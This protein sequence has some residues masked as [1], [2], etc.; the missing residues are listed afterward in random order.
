M[1]L[2]IPPLQAHGDNKM[3]RFLRKRSAARDIAVYLDTVRAMDDRSLADTLA[4]ALQLRQ[5]LIS[6]GKGDLM[7]PWE[8][9]AGN[10]LLPMELQDAIRHWRAQ[11]DLFSMTRASGA[12]L[13]LHTLQ[14]VTY[15]EL[16]GK[17]RELWGE[18]A[19]GF[20]HL[21][22]PVTFPKG[23]NSSRPATPCRRTRPFAAIGLS[24]AG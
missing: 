2:P 7:T 4:I 8:T 13:W 20:P 16:R 10:P 21:S 22:E 9:V 5:S 14:A 17:A 12:V 6:L 3:Y 23:L 1:G 24:V 11:G 18:F 19:R 15:E